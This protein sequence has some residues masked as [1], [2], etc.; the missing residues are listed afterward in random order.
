[1]DNQHKPPGR[2][3]GIPRPASKL[4]VPSNTPSKLVRPTP[5]RERLQKNPP[6]DSTRLQNPSDGHIFKKPLP[7]YS[8]ATRNQE[9]RN[10]SRPASRN[11]REESTERDGEIPWNGTAVSELDKIADDLEHRGRSKSTRPS[12]SDRTVETLSQIP[13]SPLSTRRRSSFFN[14]TSPARSM[15]RPGSAMSGSRS[16]SEASSRQNSGSEIYAPSPSGLRL[17]SRS[18]VPAVPPLPTNGAADIAPAMNTPSKFRRPSR[19]SL[20][21]ETPSRPTAS[22]RIDVASG[23]TNLF[24]ERKSTTGAATQ[25]QSSFRKP[26]VESFKPEVHEPAPLNVKKTRKTPSTGASQSSTPSKPSSTRPVPDRQDEPDPKPAKSSTA[27]R[28]SIAKAKA[29]SRNAKSKPQLQFGDPWESVDD[30]FNQQPKESNKG[31]LR[32]RVDAGR[33]TGHLN[34]AAMSLTEIP[35]EVMTM[36]DFDPDGS[37]DWYESVDL[38]KF[39][40]A[41]NELT[42]LAD[43]AFPDVD[44][45][46]PGSDLDEKGNQFAGLETLDLH[47]NLLQSLPIG[48]R[49]LKRLHSLNLSHNQLTMDD[50]MVV[51]QLDSLRDLKLANN[52]LEGDFTPEIGHLRALEVLHLDGNSLTSLPETLSE[53]SALKVLSLGRNQLTSLPFEILS[54]LPLKEITAQEN[55]LDG[56][57]MPESVHELA[58]LQSLDITSNALKELSSGSVQLPNLHTLAMSANRIQS[59]PDM[60][61]WT[62][63]L[64]ISAQDNALKELPPGFLELKNV[65]NVDFTGNDISR[66]D[67]RVGLMESLVTFRIAN[68][69]LRERKFLT[70][71][72]EDLQRDLHSR[73]EPEQH[74]GNDEGLANVQSDSAPERPNQSLWQIKPGGIL[75]RSNTNMENLEMAQ[76]EQLDAQEIQCLYLQHNQLRQF[77]L[78]ISMLDNLVDLD[79]SNNP[80]DGSSFLSSP[81]TTARLKKLNLTA[82]GITTLEPLLAN[83]SAPMLSS[84]DISLNRLSGSL[85]AFRH[86]YADL[87]SLFAPNNQLTTLDFDAVQGLQT[88]DVR[89]NDIG[90]LPPRLGLLRAQGSSRNWAGGSALRRFDVTGNSFRVPRWQLVEKGTEAILDW[91]KNRIPA[92]E[93]A[94]CESD[95]ELAETF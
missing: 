30:P 18:R 26:S 12:L 17:P 83:L 75:D 35:Q 77:P 4:P 23:R 92:K 25:N 85:P 41:D 43:A 21:T 59:L 31:L 67:E 29:A 22:K 19:Q 20:A 93:L 11:D 1:M 44:P 45:E 47:G 15:S 66:L 34:I 70:M 89:N 95:D 9:N 81:V 55:K 36:Y 38:V 46:D 88:L 65:R 94:E 2:P 64:T 60:S 16:P 32:K 63:L 86:I 6:R 5:S 80:L 69:P 62:A 27:L 13:P 84:L 79:L 74:D 33:T 24:S 50:L 73:C 37:A 7:K 58:T 53:L 71:A 51:M 8:A 40:A 78:A 56:V 90:S 52:R 48:L 39:I 82:T 68:N 87:D 10:N 61:S 28:E 49:Q 72:T 14:A 91:L 42:E 57:L 76:V 54:G 3:S